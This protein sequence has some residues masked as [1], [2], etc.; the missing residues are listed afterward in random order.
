[1]PDTNDRE[2]MFVDGPFQIHKSRAED[3]PFAPSSDE[4]REDERDS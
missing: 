4:V 1:M 2:E 3:A